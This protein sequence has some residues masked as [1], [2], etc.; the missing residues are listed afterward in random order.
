MI[1]EPTHIFYEGKSLSEHNEMF[2]LS[3]HLR[4]FRILALKWSIIRK[5]YENRLERKKKKKSSLHLKL[6]Y[7]SW[8]AS[9]PEEKIWTASYSLHFHLLDTKTILYNTTE[10]KHH[11]WFN[12]QIFCSIFPGPNDTLFLQIFFNIVWHIHFIPSE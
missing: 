11:V 7:K 8:W 2:H 5:S 12:F 6:K 3:S 4:Y 9:H 1:Y 10:M